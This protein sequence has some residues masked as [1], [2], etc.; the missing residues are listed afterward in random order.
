MSYRGDIGI[1]LTNTGTEPFDVHQGDKICQLVL[2]EVPII[3]WVPVESLDETARGE[4]GFNSTGV[5]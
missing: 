3:E 1:I 4:G 2:Q 5:Q